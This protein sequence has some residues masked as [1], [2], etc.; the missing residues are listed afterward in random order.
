MFQRLGYLQVLENPVWETWPG[1]TCANL[2]ETPSE[3]GG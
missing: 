1:A 2:T 3:K